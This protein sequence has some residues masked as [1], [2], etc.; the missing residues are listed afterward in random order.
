MAGATDFAKPEHAQAAAIRSGRFFCRVPQ[1]K[2]N[3][4]FGDAIPPSSRSKFPA[5][6][7]LS[8]CGAMKEQ[9]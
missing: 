4:T 6:L 2:A 8:T 7:A 1:G 3:I 9:A 5:V